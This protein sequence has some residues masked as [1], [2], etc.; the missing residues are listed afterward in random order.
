MLVIYWGNCEMKK[1]K[2]VEIVLNLSFQ[3]L[4]EKAGIDVP[5]N[6]TFY[7]YNPGVFQS[8]FC[9]IK[10]GYELEINWKENDE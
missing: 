4:L 8:G 9:F 1:Y 10:K 7:I 3:E 5:E 2:T 6:A